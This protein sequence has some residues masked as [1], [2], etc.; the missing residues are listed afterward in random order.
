[1]VRGVSQERYIEV[2][3][4]LDEYDMSICRFIL[5]VHEEDPL[6]ALS[7]YLSFISRL[8][9]RLGDFKETA[10][11]WILEAI[12]IDKDKFIDIFAREFQLDNDQDSIAYS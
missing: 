5:Q 12:D 1:M 7:A 3:T 10:L 6:F 8:I 4:R 11:V 9:E 2:L